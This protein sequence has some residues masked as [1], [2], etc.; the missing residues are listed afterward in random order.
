MT[1]S[2]ISSFVTEIVFSLPSSL[3]FALC[4]KVH[5]S[6]CLICSLWGF[7][8]S[9]IIMMSKNSYNYN[10]II[11]EECAIWSLHEWF[12]LCFCS[13][14]LHKHPHVQYT[15]TFGNQQISYLNT[16]DIKYFQL[17]FTHLKNVIL[18]QLLALFFLQY[19]R[20][21]MTPI[22]TCGQIHCK[23][24]LL[25]VNPAYKKQTKRQLQNELTVETMATLYFLFLRS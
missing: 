2:L 18:T 23:C 13:Q 21:P 22:C 16:I 17:H 11:S 14:S 3:L 8:H 1:L 20:N 5:F 15:S 4:K 9:C 24:E 6:F 10:L 25:I 7:S 12:L 19:Q